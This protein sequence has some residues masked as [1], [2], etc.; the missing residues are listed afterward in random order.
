MVDCFGATAGA[1]CI[2]QICIIASTSGACDD[3][4]GTFE[5]GLIECEGVVCNGCPADLN[6]DGSVEVND[7]IEVIAS[8]GACP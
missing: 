8:W 4:N 6:G 5:D 1:C 3:A 2:G 7:I